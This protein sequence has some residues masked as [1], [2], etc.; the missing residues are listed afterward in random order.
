MMTYFKGA[1]PLI[2]IGGV[3]LIIIGSA[4]LFMMSTFQPKVSLYFGSGAF[5]AKIAYTEADR[6]KGYG[7]VTNIADNEALILVFPSNDLWRIWMKD[8][9]VPIDIVWLN[10]D[11]KVIHI[12]KNASPDTGT[13]GTYVP[14]TP[15]RYVLELA[16]GTVDSKAIAVGRSAIFEVNHK[17]VE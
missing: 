17:D 15:A 3:L 14:K 12:V 1:S 7:G 2:I 11:K 4:V 6:Q 8:M 5:D 10:E 16:A 13:E 9:K